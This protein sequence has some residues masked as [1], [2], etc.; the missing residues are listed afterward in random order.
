MKNLKRIFK[1]VII[2]ILLLLGEGGFCLLV[3]SSQVILMS[4]IY[5]WHLKG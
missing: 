5:T 4:T 2:K 3:S 1:L